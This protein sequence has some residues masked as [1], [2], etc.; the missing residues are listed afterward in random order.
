[1]ITGRITNVQRFSIHDGPGI[2]TT[3]FFKGCDLRCLWCHNPETQ[4]PAP[5]LMVYKSRCVGCGDCVKFC[6]KS[7]TPACTACGK[8]VAVCSHG[9]REIVGKMVS[10][11]EIF[12]TV[13]RDKAYYDTSGGGVTLSGGEP[14]L[15]PDFAS[16]LLGLCKD[17]GI[18][19]AIE[20][21]LNV[22][23]ETAESL[24]PMLDLVICDIKGLDP[25]RHKENTG[26]S[27]ERILDN[28]IK[29]KDSGA[30]I[31]FR[32]PYVPGR[33]DTEAEEIVRFAAPFGLELMPYHE[34]GVGKYADLGVGYALPDV[35]PPDPAFMRELAAGIGAIYDPSGV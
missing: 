29:L 8:C 4:S 32:M 3:V 10:A 28:I 9:A 2:R 11:S 16:E 17:A 31:L 30:D 6:N 33:N 1:M 15:Q 21:A 26:V 5:Q 12:D 7:F 34:T 19:T 35:R 27:N 22:P 18:R 23:W 13:R 20:T 14:L 24:L 25:V